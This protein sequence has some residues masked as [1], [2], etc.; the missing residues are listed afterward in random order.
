MVGEICDREM[1]NI[2]IRAAL[3]G[4]LV[5]ST[6]HTNDASGALTRLIAMEIEP[7]LIASSVELIIAQRLVRRFCTQCSRSAQFEPGYLESCLAAL[8]IDPK[9]KLVYPSGPRTCWLRLLPSDWI[10][11]QSRYFRDSRDR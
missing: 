3:T 9:E 2:G 10:S 5:L 11:R 6:L 4:H 8:G 1:A 7:F